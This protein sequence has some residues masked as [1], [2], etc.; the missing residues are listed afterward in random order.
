[1]ISQKRMDENELAIFNSLNNIKHMGIIV[2]PLLYQHMVYPK[3]THPNNCSNDNLP[4]VLSF[5]STMTSHVL[6]IY[7]F[8]Q[9][10]PD[11]TV[12]GLLIAIFL[13][14]SQFVQQETNGNY[15]TTH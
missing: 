5:L 9:I 7:Y 13:I 15:Q 10:F 4:S 8:N 12:I 1:M 14:S 11:Q 2:A 6:F 3:V